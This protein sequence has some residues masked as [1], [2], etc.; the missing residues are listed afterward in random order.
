[1]NDNKDF[2]YARDSFDEYDDDEYCDWGSDMT[3]EMRNML[4]AFG[5]EI[6][7]DL[8]ASDEE[9]TKALSD[10]IKSID[11]RCSTNTEPFIVE[12]FE[13]SID[14]LDKYQYEYRYTSNDFT[15]FIR[16]ITWLI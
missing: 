9:I 16:V 8:N 6:K 1:M 5:V 10:A 14:R 12:R 7:G 13:K 3:D 2:E 11:Y 4:D 15:G